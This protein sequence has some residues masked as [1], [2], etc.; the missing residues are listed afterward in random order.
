M[1]FAFCSADNLGH[2]HKTGFDVLITS[3]MLNLNY[4]LIADIVCLGYAMQRDQ[5]KKES[6]KIPQRLVSDGSWGKSYLGWLGISSGR[7]KRMC[8][9]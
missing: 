3:M 8:L 7:E 5:T 2:T 1:I 4:L 6:C 9:L